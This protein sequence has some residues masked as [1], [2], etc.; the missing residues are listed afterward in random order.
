VGLILRSALIESDRMADPNA[1]HLDDPNRRYVAP[2]SINL[3]EDLKDKG[4]L[5]TRDL[6]DDERR[7]RHRT[8]DMT[9]PLRNML[10][11]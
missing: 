8:V 3:F 7:R 5:Q 2:Q 6:S 10:L 1:R 11:I 4:L 9:I